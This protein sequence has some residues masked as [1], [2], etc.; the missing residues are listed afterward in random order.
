M[1]SKKPPLNFEVL[2]RGPLI[3][4]E[5]K[6]RNFFNALAIMSGRI[7]IYRKFFFFGG[8]VESGEKEEVFLIIRY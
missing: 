6:S 1:G 8:V 7:L 4:S 3:V 2:K 5:L